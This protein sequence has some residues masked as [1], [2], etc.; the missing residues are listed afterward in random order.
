M[1]A[2]SQG[3]PGLEDVPPLLEP[4]LEC[5]FIRLPRISAEDDRY[6]SSGS[7]A[8]SCKCRSSRESSMWILSSPR[9]GPRVENKIKKLFVIL[10]EDS[11]LREGELERHPAAAQMGLRSARQQPDFLPAHLLLSRPLFCPLSGLWSADEGYALGLCRGS[12]QRSKPG[13]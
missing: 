1:A 2:M 3:L 10:G 11:D 6:W 7:D 12:P 13:Q 4:L 9:G 8:K 5:S